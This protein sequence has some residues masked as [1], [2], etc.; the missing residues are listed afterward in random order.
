M[1]SSKQPF[2]HP[3]ARRYPPE[4]KERAVRVGAAEPVPGHGLGRVE[5][6]GAAGDRLQG[7]SYGRR[8]DGAR[9]FR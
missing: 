3:S 1:S 5:L 6:S 9:P 7:C 4:L 8:D 2:Q